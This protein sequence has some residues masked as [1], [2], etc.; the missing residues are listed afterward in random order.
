MA[1]EGNIKDPWGTQH[2]TLAQIANYYAWYN[3]DIS[4]EAGAHIVSG[5]LVVDTWKSG[6][7]VFQFHNQ[8]TSASATIIAKDAH[9]NETT[10]VL[11]AHGYTGKLPPITHIKVT[12]TSDNLTVFTQKFA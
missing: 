7:I 8:S 3:L 6:E 11:P 4:G 5:Y 12:G 2:Q 9:G 10:I 1:G